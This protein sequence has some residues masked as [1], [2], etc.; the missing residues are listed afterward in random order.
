V[1]LL[2]VNAMAPMPMLVVPPIMLMIETTTS[3]AMSQMA[4]VAF[5]KAKTQN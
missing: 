1:V 2:Q 4:S 3:M 5:S